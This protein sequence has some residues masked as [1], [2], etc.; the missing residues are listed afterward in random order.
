VF[1]VVVVA[2]IFLFFVIN[3]TILKDVIK[4]PFLLIPLFFLPFFFNSLRHTFHP[5]AFY[6]L[7]TAIF[8][9]LLAH[10]KEAESL[11]VLFLLF[12]TRESTILLGLIVTVVSWI[13]S[14]K[15]L[16]IVALVVVVIS[17]FTTSAISSIGKSN[18]H[19]LGNFSYLVAKLSYNFM[20]NAFGAKLWV[21]TYTN[22]EPVIKLALPSL[23]QLGAIREVGF[24]GFNFLLPLKTLTVLLTTFGIAPLILF[25]ML[26]KK[27]G[28]IFKEPPFWLSLALVYGLA[29]YF[30]A[31]PAGT[32]VVRLVGYAWPA[33][34]LAV[35]IF[36]GMFLELNRK[37]I[38]KLSAIHLFVAW[39]PLIVVKSL[40]D[41]AFTTLL[42][43]LMTL[44]AY[45]YTFNAIRHKLIKRAQNFPF[46]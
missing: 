34:L 7:L 3:I 38:I 16:A 10:K 8:F 20:A 24:C 39:L 32:G 18:V 15:L 13:R 14:K 36:M 9:L 37:L 17:L 40:G 42:I 30:I 2:S 28:Q 44:G 29:H 25:S 22:C 27:G 19:D 4:S 21:N 33:F 1:S 6:I 12:L 46:S 5:D 35:P 45:I 26:L 41:T 43:I 31:I 11:L 23:K